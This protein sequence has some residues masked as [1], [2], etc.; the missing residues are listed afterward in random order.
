LQP[1]IFAQPGDINA[2]EPLIL[3]NTN[4]WMPN[5]HTI[6]GGYSTF[7]A[8]VK[9]EGFRVN[10]KFMTE[11]T[12]DQLAGADI[13]VLAVPNFSLLTE[14]KAI[15]DRFIQNGGG[16]LLLVYPY[17]TDLSN[18]GSFSRDYGITFGSKHLAAWT[19]DVLQDSPFNEPHNCSTIG[20][21][22]ILNYL[23]LKVDVSKAE[24]AA[25]MKN[26]SIIGSF[27]RASKLGK[28]RLVLLGTDVLFHSSSVHKYDNM[29]FGLNIMH[30]LA[31]GGFDLQLKK[32][33]IKKKYH[34]A[35]EEITCIA[36]IKNIGNGDSTET[37]VV[38]YLTD[39]GSLSTSSIVK[40]LG[41]ANVPVIKGGKKTKIKYSAVLPTW[42]GDG[43]YY[44]FAVIDPED[45]SG[46]SNIDNNSKAG[47]KITVE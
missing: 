13:F 21:L 36:K 37:T 26:G 19:A 46:D 1:L 28:G 20:L 43:D 15:L 8:R 14:H 41:E 25:R 10:Q 11:I 38:F 2:K 3:L 35:S 17:S 42:L 27:S 31:G 18:I 30:Y 33:K 9:N 24:I 39:N 12:E 7:W 34:Q 5:F 47:N 32:A 40:N 23:K 22:K 29:E 16:I 44:T 4:T 6:Q 45:T